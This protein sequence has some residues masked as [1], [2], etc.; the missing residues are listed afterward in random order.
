MSNTEYRVV[1]KFFS[2][3]GLNVTELTKELPDVYDD[4]NVSY[5]TVAKLTTEFN[6]LTQGFEDAPR[7]TR[8]PITVTDESI[9]VVEEV[10]MRTIDKLLFDA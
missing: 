9:R 7:S 6:D 3:K 8:P 1:I 2:R 4:S 10:V 5:H